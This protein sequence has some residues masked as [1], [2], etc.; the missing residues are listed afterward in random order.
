M[1]PRPVLLQ[2]VQLL[3]LV[4]TVGGTG[5]AVSE[6]RVTAGSTPRAVASTA[7]KVEF[8]V[9]I[10]PVVVRQAA[11]AALKSDDSERQDE[12]RKYEPNWDSLMTRPLP[13]WFDEAKTG[14]FIHWGIYSVP[15]F[16]IANISK[17]E[18]DGYA[19]EW[20]WYYL[21]NRPAECL[22]TPEVIAFQNR[23]FREGSTYSDFADRFKAELFYPDDWAKLFVDAGVKYVVLTS[24]HHEG[25]CNWC[26]A[27]AWNWN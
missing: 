7:V 25:W 1:L 22:P 5:V 2:L 27:Q 20:Y 9:V 26:S 8:D 11:P 13:S 14:V 6:L 19:A 3:M 23:S 12:R 18:T 15:S 21:D 24:K 4:A 16:N 17:A 10:V